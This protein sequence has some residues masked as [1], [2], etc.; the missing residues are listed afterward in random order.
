MPAVPLNAHVSDGDQ[1]DYEEMGD[2]DG[3]VLVVVMVLAMGMLAIPLVAILFFAVVD[4]GV[5]NTDAVDS[6]PNNKPQTP[7]AQFNP[8]PKRQIL[9]AAR[10][11]NAHSPNKCMVARARPPLQIRTAFCQKDKAKLCNTLSPT[12]SN[13]APKPSQGVQLLVKLP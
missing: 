8:K 12:V 7:K 13:P 5:L 4:D 9:V 11:P 3:N 2:S 1:E 6:S 10:S